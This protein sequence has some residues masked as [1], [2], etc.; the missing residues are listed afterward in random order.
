MTEDAPRPRHR[1]GGLVAVVGRIARTSDGRARFR[2]ARG[3]RPPARAWMSLPALLAHRRRSPARRVPWIAPE[4]VRRLD[5]LAEPGWRVLEFGAGDSTHWFAA[6]AASVV[7][8]ETDRAWHARVAQDLASS[9]LDNCELLLRAR[10]DV[11]AV[12][13]DFPDDHFDL[14]VV[15]CAESAPGERIDCV[16]AAAGE[17]RPGGYLLLDDSDRPAYRG[18]DEVLAGWAVAR[19]VGMKPRPLAAVETSLYRRAP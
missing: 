11:A 2:T 16:R 17:V 1:D 4:A 5:R 3:G 7:S 18:A 12:A 9:R 14:I 8:V 13:R 6:R 15:D 10:G 19:F